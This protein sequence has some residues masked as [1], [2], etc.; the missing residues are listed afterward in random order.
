VDRF[1][2]R[3]SSVLLNFFDENYQLLMADSLIKKE[4][5]YSLDVFRGATVCL[6]IMVNNPG[7]W[8][9]IYAPLDHAEWHGITPTDLV[10]HFFFLPLGMRWHLL[11]RVSKKVATKFSGKK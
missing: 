4:R 1:N 2:L 6:M 3:A 8:E 9:H 10:S 7:S 5:F 11:C